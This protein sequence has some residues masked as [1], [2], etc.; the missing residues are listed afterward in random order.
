MFNKEHCDK[1]I[2]QY[3]SVILKTHRS[4]QIGR[5]CRSEFLEHSGHQN[6]QE[7]NGRRMKLS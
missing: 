5:V 3:L 7:K 2:V 6:K 4:G 1:N